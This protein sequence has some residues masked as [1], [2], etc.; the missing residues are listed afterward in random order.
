[1]KEVIQ[2]SITG[3]TT[4]RYSSLKEASEELGITIGAISNCLN[5][6]TSTCNHSYWMYA[7]DVMDIE[8]EKELQEFETEEEWLNYIRKDYSRLNKAQRFS[9][10]LR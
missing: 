7:E 5:K 1:M 4:K 8:C 10:L 3:E 6:R 2:I 9:R